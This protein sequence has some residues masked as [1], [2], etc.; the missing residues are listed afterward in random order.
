MKKVLSMRFSDSN[1]ND[2]PHLT[3]MP[4][5]IDLVV[6]ALHFLGEGDCITL[7]IEPMPEN[8]DQSV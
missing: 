8:G 7:L 2:V 1:G 5:N 6:S 4:A 3:K